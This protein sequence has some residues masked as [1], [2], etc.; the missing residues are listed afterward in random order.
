MI[1]T[2][3]NDTGRPRVKRRVGPETRPAIEP[4]DLRF[5]LSGVQAG[6]WHSDNPYIS[7]FWNALSI[8]FPDGER[9][10]MDSVRRVR[11]E[12]RDGHLQEQ[13]RAFLSQEG[14]HA[15]EHRA[16]NDLLREQGYPAQWPERLTRLALW[17]TRVTSARWQLA[18]T[19]A[20]EHFTATLA[21]LVLTSEETRDLFGH[22]EVRNLFVWHAL[23]ESEHKAVAFDVYRAVGGSE[24]FH[25]DPTRYS[26]AVAAYET[27]TGVRPFRRPSLG[28]LLQSIVADEP[29]RASAVNRALPTAVD[30]VLAKALARPLRAPGRRGTAERSTEGHDVAIDQPQRRG[31]P[32]VVPYSSHGLA[33]VPRRRVASTSFTSVGKGPEPT[34]VWKLLVTPTTRPAGVK[35][36]PSPVRAPGAV[37]VE[38]VTKG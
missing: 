4:R 14:I 3:Q 10:F 37:G 29:P 6:R 35:P 36:M 27:L 13:I 38:L 17:L 12:I 18:L 22:E 16:Y 9:F 24:R 25:R 15:R 5:D 8:T 28:A 30:W 19:C 20:L 21:E 32:V 2:S 23:E 31:R 7:H 33:P 11:R 26:L 1:T 34:R